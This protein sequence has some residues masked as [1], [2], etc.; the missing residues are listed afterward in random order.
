M[1]RLAPTFRCVCL[2]APGTGRSAWPHKGI[3]LERT[4]RAV[5]GVISAL[6]LQDVTLIAHD[7][8]GIAGVVGAGR[9]PARFIG[10]AAI[11]GFAWRPKGIVFRGILRFMGSSIIRELD[12]LTGVIPRV[13]ATSVGVG[14]HL[15]DA[16]RRAFLARLNRRGTRAFH[17]YLG[18]AARC[19]ALYE[20]AAA[21]LSDSFANLPVLTI[22]GER[23]D[24]FH[25]QAQ[26]KRRFP[27]VQQ[28][29][30]R[31]GNHFPMCDDPEL[32]ASTLRVW[33]RERCKALLR[34]LLHD[35]G[36]R[37]PQ[38]APRY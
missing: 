18:D 29:V 20:E 31:R 14:R 5:A 3:T 38:S 16:S 32:V 8:G 2:D 17:K 12:A 22:F 30:V 13:T 4:A 21:T 9:S 19:D 10:L 1:I 6:N 24:P 27:H 26:W 36:T 7:L 28:V 33:H 11:N 25:F 37:P 23:N 34:P 15:D 35:E